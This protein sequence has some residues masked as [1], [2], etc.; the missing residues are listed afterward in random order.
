MGAPHDEALA[1]GAAQGSKAYETT[2]AA[3]VE[4]ETIGGKKVHPAANLFPLLDPESDQ[5]KKLALSIKH[6]QQ[7]EPIVLDSEDRILD[8]RN[9]M[10]VCIELGIEPR[11][12]YFHDLGLV[13]KDGKPVDAAEY[14]YEKNIAR[15]DL[16]DDQRVMIVAL[17]REYLD[18]IDRGA[19]KGNKNAAKKQG[20]QVVPAKAEPK[21]RAK[22]AAKAGV[23]ERKAQQALN[24]GRKKPDLAKKVA[25]GNMKLSDAAKQAEPKKPKRAPPVQLDLTGL[26]AA[27]DVVKVEDVQRV[28]A[29]PVE[30]AAPL[31]TPILS[32]AQALLFE[33]TLDECAKELRR[34]RNLTIRHQRATHPD[35]FS[36]R[37]ALLAA[38]HALPAPDGAADPAKVT[39]PE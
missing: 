18:K 29:A 37:K 30:E 11:V 32:A 34:I 35:V 1:G 24:V 3:I 20:D 28:D 27:I 25:A 21:T 16:T 10:R 33:K 13:N 5:Y 7:F 9:R 4:P 23:S 12:R 14:A 15:R 26:P 22:L 31:V 2:D 17:Y 39:R 8:G 6:N 36:A 38:L 19:P